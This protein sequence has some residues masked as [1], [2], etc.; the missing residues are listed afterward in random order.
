MAE[1]TLIEQDEDLRP[2]E[3][4]LAILVFDRH[5]VP[6]M[7]ALAEAAS[8]IKTLVEALRLSL[9]H[10]DENFRWH[11]DAQ[12]HAGRVTAAYDALEAAKAALALTDNG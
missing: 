6:S 2:C 1:P 5:T 4:C 12:S 7:D 11:R 8:L 3:T 9:P 10:L